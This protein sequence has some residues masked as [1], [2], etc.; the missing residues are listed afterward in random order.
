MTPDE[1]L[2]CFIGLLREA[3]A[4]VVGAQ[5]LCPDPELGKILTALIC[6][7][8][9]LETWATKRMAPVPV[10]RVFDV[11]GPRVPK[12]TP[13]GEPGPTGAAA[14]GSVPPE[15]VPPA[16]TGESDANADA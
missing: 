10:A 14:A 7:M 2:Q 1:K 13:G 5:E 6:R 16:N 11:A 15:P 8:A 12:L 4:H 3:H 9:E